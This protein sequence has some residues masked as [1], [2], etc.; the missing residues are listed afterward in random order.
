M[1]SQNPQQQLTDGMENEMSENLLNS[2]INSVTLENSHQLEDASE[3]L[4]FQNT[5][6]TKPTKLDPKHC[7]LD[8][9]GRCV[10]CP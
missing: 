10:P 2:E 5:I 7:C 3:N 9:F 6:N 1:E 8:E 4:E